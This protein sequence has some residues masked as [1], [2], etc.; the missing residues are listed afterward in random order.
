M[1]GKVG[2]DM[3]EITSVNNP[4]IKKVRSLYRKKDRIKNKSFI[5]EGIKIIEEGI[6]SNYPLKNIVYTDKLLDTK[7]GVEFFDKIKD[8]KSLVYVPNNIFI[9]ISDTENPQGVL[10]IAG[11]KNQD[12]EEIKD[13]ENPF[14]LFLDEL[15][16]PGNMG[17][18]IRTADAFNIDCIIISEGSVD[19]YNP[20]VVRAT[21]GSIFR[22]PLYNVL[23][24]IKEL[25]ELKEKGIKI[26]STSL[27]NSISIYEQDFTEG[28]IL[29]IGNESKGVS[30]DLLSLSDKLIKIP[31]PGRAESL[32]AGVAASII[33]YEARKQR[34]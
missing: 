19:P 29:T 20:K 1:E 2:A 9:D 33:M 28:F 15:Q 27:E 26:Y 11:I 34:F 7:D 4:L 14:I 24:G 32:N 23:D 12:I 13:I 17:T 8:L 21:M 16:D 3:L 10:A 25:N 5:I 22:V 31:M 18:I 6:N 30:K